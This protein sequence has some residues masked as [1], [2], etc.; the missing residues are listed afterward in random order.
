MKKDPQVIDRAA[1]EIACR[2]LRSAQPLDDMLKSKALE[3]IL[4][5]VARKHMQRLA[6]RDIK[7]L[8]ANDID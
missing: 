2:I 1:L 3:I 5:N 8:Q 4:E 6:Q 7:K